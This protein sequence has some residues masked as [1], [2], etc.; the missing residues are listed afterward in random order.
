MSI[1]ETETCH[2]ENFF[3]IEKE[4]SKSKNDFFKKFGKNL[5]KSEI[6]FQNLDILSKTEKAFKKSDDFF[7]NR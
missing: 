2:E 1:M 4:N 7:Q 3:K 6:F 5:S